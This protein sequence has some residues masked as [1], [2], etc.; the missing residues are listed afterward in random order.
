MGINRAGDVQYLYMPII[1]LKAFGTTDKNAS[2][3]IIRNMSDAHSKQSLIY[4]DSSEFGLAF[5]IKTFPSIPEEICPE[6]A[7]SDKFLTNTS[8]S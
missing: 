3:A 6:V 5:V 8:W 2:A 1:I 7:L 4:T